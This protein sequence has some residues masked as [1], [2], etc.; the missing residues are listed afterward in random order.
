M[1]E[2]RDELTVTSQAAVQLEFDPE[3]VQ[4]EKSP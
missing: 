2:A 4:V 1:P 3:A